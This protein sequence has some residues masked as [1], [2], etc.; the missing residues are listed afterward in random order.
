MDSTRKPLRICHVAYSFYESDNRVIRYAEATAVRGDHVD[1]ITLRR[2]AAARRWSSDGVS[3]LGIQ[4][5]ARNETAAWT[6]LVKILWFFVQTFVVLC[7]RSIRRPYDVV[8]VHN[9]PDFLV[10]AALPAKLR[11]ARVILDIH[12]AVPELYSGKFGTARRSWLDRCLLALERW[13]CSFAD[14]VILANHLWLDTVGKRSCRP[15]NCTVLLNYPDLRM[16][17]V[18]RKERT[19]G[20]PFVFVYPGTLNHHQGLDVAIDALA[21]IQSD[22]PTVELH[23]YGEG[24]ALPELRAQA[25]RL[26]LTSRVLFKERVP[27]TSIP[28]ILAGADVGIVPKRADGFGNEAFSTKILEL[29]AASVPVIVSRTRIDSHYFSDE[30]VRFFDPGNASALALQMKSAYQDPTALVPTI[31]IGRELAVSYSWAKHAPLYIDIVD[32]AG[33]ESSRGDIPMA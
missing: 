15:N 1:V 22:C 16:F 10:F 25:A 19:E 28:E 21:L 14:H 8:H 7:V 13:S 31:A 6:Y 17:N 26:G 23:I 32:T 9:I 3:A 2:P 24:P 30:Q 27:I 20:S 29:M 4:T 12:D 5:R 18:P 33:V 11:G